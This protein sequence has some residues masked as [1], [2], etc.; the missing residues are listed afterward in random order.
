MK[1]DAA[2]KYLANYAEPEVQQLADFP[3]N[4]QFQHCMVIPVY[5]ET[6]EFFTRLQLGP[7][8]NQHAL[9]IAVINQPDTDDDTETNDL[10]IQQICLSG[11]VL[12]Y[13]DN[14]QLLR[15]SGSSNYW[16]VVDRYSFNHHTDRRLPRRE[17]VGLARKIGCDLAAALIARSQIACDWIHSTDADVFLPKDYFELPDTAPYSAAIYH[18]KHQ[19]D[20]SRV[21]EATAVYERALHYYVQGLAWAGSH[22]AYHTIGSILA[23]NAKRY[24]QA[25]GFPRRSGGE[26]FYLLNK[27]AKLAPLHHANQTLRIKARQSARVPFGTGPAVATIMRYENP[28]QEYS[29]YNPGTFVALREWLQHVPQVWRAISKGES[30]MHGLS[31]PVR[32]ALY[33]VGWPMIQDHLERQA[34]SAEDSER[35]LRDWFDAFRTLKFI[36]HL[37]AHE[38]PPQ[39]LA[40]CLVQAEQV[41]S[42]ASTGH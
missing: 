38:Y 1:D 34:K 18:F 41:F 28:W 29:Y 10:L 12:W 2:L 27:L 5:N 15:H 40:Q 7:L 26:D 37:Q 25:R 14:I 11:E 20:G 8:H 23:I 6:A 17:G 4:L 36:H 35:A 31:T 22:Y 42:Q 19:N 30:P 9:C 24:C 32:E 3:D 21:G 13:N 33:A 16:L 39:P